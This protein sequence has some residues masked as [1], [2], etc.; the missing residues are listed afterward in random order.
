[1]YSQTQNICPTYGL[2]ESLLLAWA[3]FSESSKEEVQVDGGYFF[4]CKNRFPGQEAFGFEPGFLQAVTF[5]THG[6]TLQ[7]EPIKKESKGSPFGRISG[8]FLAYQI[9]CR[10]RG[11]TD[12]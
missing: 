1:M 7:T 8:S 6:R 11:T 5:Q 3:S 4:L 2:L 12:E 9:P 10:Y